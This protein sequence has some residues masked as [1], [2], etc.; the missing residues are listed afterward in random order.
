MPLMPAK[1]QWDPALKG[2]GKIVY[3]DSFR[4]KYKKADIGKKQFVCPR[5]DDPKYLVSVTLD[6]ERGMIARMV[7]EHCQ[8]NDLLKQTIKL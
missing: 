5:R 8:D 2:N 1:T 7:V 6:D 3:Q 4:M